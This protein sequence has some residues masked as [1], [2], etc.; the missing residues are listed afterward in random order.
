VKYPKEYR[1]R[2]IC[3][4][5]SL[6]PKRDRPGAARAVKKPK[7]MKTSDES[8]RPRLKPRGPTMPVD[9]LGMSVDSQT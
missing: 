9:T 1:A 3:R 5:P 8:S 7:K 2:T 6:V 4:R